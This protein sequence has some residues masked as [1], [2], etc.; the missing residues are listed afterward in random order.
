MKKVWIGLAFILLTACS[1][2]SNG[3]PQ[4]NTDVPNTIESTANQTKTPSFEKKQECYK[5]KSAVEKD[6][7]NDDEISNEQDPK[8]YIYVTNLVEIFYSPVNDTCIAELRIFVYKDRGLEQTDSS[9]YTFKDVLTNRD[10][11]DIWVEGA[12]V[13]DFKEA[14]NKVENEYFELSGRHSSDYTGS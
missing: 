13:T 2:T 10:L 14:L 5:Y 9:W 11:A 3:H 7:K 6:E 8:G 12:N 4:A 1:S